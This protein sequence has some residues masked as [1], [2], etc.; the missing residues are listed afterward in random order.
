MSKTR[1]IPSLPLVVE[2]LRAGLAAP[3]PGSAAQRLMAPLPRPGWRPGELPQDARTAA[4]LLLLYPVRRTT[5]LALTVRSSHLPQHG[6]QVCLPG[7]A[8]RAGESIET[9]ALREAAEEIGIDRDAVSLLGQLTPLHIPVSGFVLHC[10]V[11][12]AASRP[13]FRPQANEVARVL[14]VPLGMLCDPAA[15]HIRTRRHEGR[16]Y[17]VPY[18]L[19]DGAI[20]WGATAMVLAEF[21]ALLGHSPSPPARTVIE[22]HASVR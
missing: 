3:L 14:D 10:M 6:G 1:T 5:H 20:V 9:T 15:V 12:Y 4:T 21:L 19:V 2:R 7:G 18:F 13:S 8:A 16:D 11:G 22:T 17:E